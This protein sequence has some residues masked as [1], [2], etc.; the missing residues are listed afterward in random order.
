VKPLMESGKNELLG[1][2]SRKRRLGIKKPTS[3][4][5]VGA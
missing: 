5:E 3:G 1:L 2:G 4:R